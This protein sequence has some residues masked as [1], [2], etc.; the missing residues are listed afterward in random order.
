MPLIK[1]EI[2]NVLRAAGLER[3]PSSGTLS[4]KL[5]LA[6][7]SED[8]ICEELSQIATSSG[9]EAIRLRAL[10]LALKTKGALKETP[11][12]IP[13]FTIVIQSASSQS[14]QSDPQ[15]NPI[16]FPR[17]SLDSINKDKKEN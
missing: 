9:N 5:D 17:T 15:V 11:P 2:Q 8:Q 1:P 6:G 16:F 10:E 12:Q 14:P 4:D 3:E 7:L 13:S